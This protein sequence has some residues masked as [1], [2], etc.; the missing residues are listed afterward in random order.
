MR[1][2]HVDL[3][4]GSV[5]QDARDVKT[6]FSKTFTTFFFPVGDEI[7]QIVD[8]WVAPAARPAV[9]QRRPAVSGHARR[10]ERAGCTSR[11]WASTASPGHGRA[12][13]GH[14]QGAFEAAGLPYYNPHS[15]RSTL[16]QLGQTGLPDA[17]GLQG[18]EPEPR[19]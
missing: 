2:K 17:R 15:L 16:V 9:G 18:L 4:A 12:H 10:A 19:A 1:L 14:L 6:K 3:A 5:F 11:R 7:R 13:P 8:E